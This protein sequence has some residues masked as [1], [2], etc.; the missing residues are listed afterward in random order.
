MFYGYG[1][2]Y[3]PTYILVIAALL[4]GVIA[5]ARMRSAFSKYSRV[6]SMR[7]LTGSE[8]ARQILAANGITDVQIERVGG[9]LT[10]HFDPRSKVLRL[11]EPVYASD[12]VAALGVA[13]HEAGH[14]V[15][16]AKGYFP[17]KLRNA[18]VPVANIGSYLALPLVIL[19]LVLSSAYHM[20]GLS[21]LIDIGIWL[22]VGVVLFQVVTLPVE[23]NA[24][25]R[26]VTALSEQN[27]ILEEERAGVKRVLTAA[28]LTYVAATLSALLQLLR[29]V[30]L[31]R[32]RR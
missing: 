4:L 32:R 14:A 10:D 9:D 22:F 6:R 3:D 21:I 25:R 23:L 15:Q 30:L 7:G 1:Y 16:H 5:Q 12:S 27:L 17:I 31:T 19:G 26:A 24:S 18:L 28:A 11:S 8:A 20:T 13:A 2:Y 29:L